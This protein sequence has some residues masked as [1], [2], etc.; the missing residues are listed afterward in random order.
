MEA[1][2][3]K[4]IESLIPQNEELRR[5][6][7]EHQKLNRKL[8]SMASQTY[9]TAEEQIERKQMQKRKLAGRDRIAAI[10]AAHREE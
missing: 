10:L 1:S 4:L 9:F 3:L 6:W 5:L 2:E 8:D 7:E